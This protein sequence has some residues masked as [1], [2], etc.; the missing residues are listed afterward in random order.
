MNKTLDLG[1]YF[2][3]DNKARRI[4]NANMRKRSTLQSWR[5]PKCACTVQANAVE[6]LHRC[7]QNR[8][9]MT[10]FELVSD[11]PM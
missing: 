7:A 2:H 10:G 9:R 11:L 4:V 6:V 8:N 1:D 5:C 3:L